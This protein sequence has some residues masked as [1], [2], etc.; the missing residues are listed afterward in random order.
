[1]DHI[2]LTLP[3]AWTSSVHVIEPHLTMTDWESTL[4]QLVRREVPNIPDLSLIH[5]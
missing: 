5:I 4:Y 3:A 2:L 1:M